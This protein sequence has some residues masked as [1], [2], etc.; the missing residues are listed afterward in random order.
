[1]QNLKS[2]REIRTELLGVRLY[3]TNVSLWH[4]GGQLNEAARQAFN[5]AIRTYEFRIQ[6][7]N[8]S[9]TIPDTGKTTFVLPQ[10]MDQI[11]EI[12]TRENTIAGTRR[13][14]KSYS[15]RPT[16][17]T[18]YLHINAKTFP[19]ARNVEIVYQSRMYEVPK[20][21]VVGTDLAGTDLSVVTS[22]VVPAVEWQTPGYF[23]LSVQQAS[24]N[25]TTRAEIVRYEWLQNNG[26]TN[27]TRNV[28]NF[29]SGAMDWT[30][31]DRISPMIEV[32][33]E[34]LPVLQHAAQA[35]MYNFWVRN[36]ALYEE[37][38][39]IASLQQLDLGDLLGL[40]RSEEDRAD[41][42][43]IKIRKPPPP[44]TASRKRHRQ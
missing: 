13:L 21:A 4:L 38:T 32:P 29:P 9:F 44:T 10:D 25:A 37:Y 26:F 12:Y 20:E 8:F 16:V 18:N 42:R 22:G 28:K 23:E 31:G 2:F 35:E 40:V 3:A 1:M 34:A 7:S 24:V 27:L 5:E 30:T 19:G 11:T 41:R 14:I 36:R 33:V 6:R 17:E 39:A 15:H 43:Y